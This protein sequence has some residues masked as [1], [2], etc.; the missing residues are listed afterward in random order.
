MAEL[1]RTGGLN[2][3]SVNRFA[4]EREYVDVAVALAF[5]SGTPVE[6]IVPVIESPDIEGLMVAC[7]AARLNWTTT[8]MIIRNR[9]RC[10]AV[11]KRELEQAEAAFDALSLSVAQRTIRLW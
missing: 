9:P 7:K 11:T 6:V 8:T 1:S 3:R 2:D 4:V 10:P 5:L